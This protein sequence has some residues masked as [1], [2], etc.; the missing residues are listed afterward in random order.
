MLMPFFAVITLSSRYRL[1]LPSAFITL[2]TP[3]AVFAATLFT[4]DVIFALF[5]HTLFVT[6][7]AAFVA[8]PL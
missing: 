1:L 3:P 5:C 2:R 6:I 7:D 4:L 8:T